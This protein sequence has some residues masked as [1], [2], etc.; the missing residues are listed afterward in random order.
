MEDLGAREAGD[1]VNGGDR[2]A[3]T[4]RPEHEKGTRLE[5]EA[6]LRVTFQDSLQNISATS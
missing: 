4:R 3:G 1:R 6:R 2:T 5:G